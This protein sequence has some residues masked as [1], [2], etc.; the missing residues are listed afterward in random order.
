L[1]RILLHL[2][3]EFSIFVYMIA[4]WLILRVYT[5]KTSSFG[6]GTQLE[7]GSIFLGLDRTLGGWNCT[8]L[9]FVFIPCIW[10]V[11]NSI[12]YFL[13]VSIM[14][15]EKDKDHLYKEYVLKYMLLPYLIFSLVTF[16][17]NLY[18]Y[19]YSGSIFECCEFWKYSYFMKLAEYYGFALSTFYF[20]YAKKGV[21]LIEG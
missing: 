2:E 7:N 15:V 18:S 8:Q 9:E 11:L 6:I 3:E 12:S 20:F 17:Y 5:D 14:K 21:F 1:V 10:V 4:A 13:A 16:V 19:K